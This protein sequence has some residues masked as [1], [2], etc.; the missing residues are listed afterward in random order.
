[1]NDEK[2]KVDYR[3]ILHL[4]LPAVQ[5]SSNG[6]TEFIPVLISAGTDKF[7]WKQSAN[8]KIEQREIIV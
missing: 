1:M 5:A 4:K 7:L 6:N 2:S 3:H 8:N